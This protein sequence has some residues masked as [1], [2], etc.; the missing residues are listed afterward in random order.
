MS[1][2]FSTKTH[3]LQHKPFLSVPN[4]TQLAITQKLIAKPP[5]FTLPTSHIQGEN[6]PAIVR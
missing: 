6:L 1:L 5:I 3:E 2:G 4:H